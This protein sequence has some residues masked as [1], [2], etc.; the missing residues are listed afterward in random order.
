MIKCSFAQ[1][2][3]SYLGHTIGAL[4]VGTDSSK[5]AALADWPTPSPIKELRSFLGLAG[6]YRRF[7]RH[8]GIISKSLTNLLKKHVLFI[9]TLEH[10]SAFQA[11][12]S[13]LCQSPVLALPS[14]SKPFTI[15]IDASDV[16][17]GAVLM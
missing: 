2:Q 4:G 14:F 9:W 1:T 8:F 3:I 5:L 7:V 15:D 13:T 10:E 6:Y 16:G 11:L 17:V 12:K